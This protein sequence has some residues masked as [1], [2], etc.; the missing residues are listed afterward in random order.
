MLSAQ[1]WHTRF[2]QQVQ[3][4]APLREY[5][6]RAANLQHA[7]SII[8]VGCGTGAL[9]DELIQYVGNHG[10][11]QIHGLD[12]DPNYIKLAHRNNRDA[13]LVLGDAHTLPYSTTSFDL[14]V[15]HFLLLWVSDPLQVIA[16]MC[17]LVRPGG[18]VLI[19]A[20]P[21]YG[22]RI[23]YP[24]ELSQLGC[25]QEESLIQQGA[26]TRLGRRLSA[27][28]HNAGLVDIETGVLGGQ[29]RDRQSLEGWQS[30]WQVIHADLNAKIDK[31][32]LEHLKIIDQQS[33]VRGER[34]L[35][36]P[37]FYSWGKVGGDTI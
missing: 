34:T 30:E 23:D 2:T 32:M 17:R 6:Y 19:L 22:G 15:C 26:D 4:T 11:K 9:L 14:A 25:W 5:L 1:E 31:E 13:R 28:M 10:A 37:T 20:E 18:A 33:S 8:E 24:E 21:D 16:E 29:W 36:V 3:W 12:I 27:I 7:S 35:Y